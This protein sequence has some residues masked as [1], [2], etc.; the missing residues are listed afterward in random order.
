MKEYRYYFRNE[1]K[2]P[3]VTVVLIA[4]DIGHARGISICSLVDNPCKKTGYDIAKGRA[5]RALKRGETGLM[6]TRLEAWNA[7]IESSISPHE[8]SMICHEK[9]HFNPSLTPFEQRLIEQKG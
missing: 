1:E 8:M 6:T 3:T 4:T 9:S 7:L 5:I 2:K